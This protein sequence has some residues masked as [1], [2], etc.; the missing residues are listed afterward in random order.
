MTAGS[1]TLL[2]QVALPLLLFAP[3]SSESVA[4][5]LTLKGG[6]NATHSPQI[7]YTQR[8]F[9]PFIKRHF[10]VYGVDLEVTRRGYFPRGGGEV[11]VRIEPPFR[12]QE[13]GQRLKGMSL[14][15]RGM[16]KAIKGIAHFAGLPGLIG[17]GMVG[18]ARRRLDRAGYGGGVGVDGRVPIEIQHTRERNDNT[19]GAGSGIVLWAELEGGGM[20][21]GS[22]VGKKG[23]DPEKLG[24]EA[25][26]E[27][28]R[29]L[30]AGGCVDEVRFSLSAKKYINN[31]FLS[32]YRTK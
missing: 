10:G 31:C 4:S 18:G 27:L 20:V 25:A 24:E 29:G 22:A 26:D 17:T 19:I 3:S 30:E 13:E 6:T 7:D 14:M 1:T 15:V 32:G 9:L 11:I 23:V 16:V 21:G 2:L 28:I 5:V 8:I 12:G